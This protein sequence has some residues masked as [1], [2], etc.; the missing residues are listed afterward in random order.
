MG[1]ARRVEFHVVRR[2]NCNPMDTEAIGDDMNPE[3]ERIR[4]AYNA[5][6]RRDR[7][8]ERRELL[9]ALGVC[10]VLLGI[11]FLVCWVM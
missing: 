10:L 2:G 11:V 3:I 9:V 6:E 8:R 4:A 1:L 5:L 7:Q